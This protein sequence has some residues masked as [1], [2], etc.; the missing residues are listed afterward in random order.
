MNDPTHPRVLVADDEDPI[1]TLVSKVLDRA[2]FDPVTV[3]D[4]GQAI[5]R[6][7]EEQFDAVVL[8]LMMPRV[9]GYA[10][11]DHLIETM[12]HMMEKTIVVTAFPQA[13]V[14]ERIHHVCRVLSKP[15][16]VAEFIAAVRECAER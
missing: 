15:F 8:D 14:R 1:R 7:H 11:V 5:E 16:D 4:G 6:L 10:V 3:A 2:G 13:A 9:D 12:P